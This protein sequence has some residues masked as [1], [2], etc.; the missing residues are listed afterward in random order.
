MYA[1]SPDKQKSIAKNADFK[2]K[3]EQAQ[4]LLFGAEVRTLQK[5]SLRASV[6]CSF[7]SCLTVA[8]SGFYAVFRQNTKR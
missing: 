2:A 7:V 4:S 3:K 5:L 1:T 8:F 6:L